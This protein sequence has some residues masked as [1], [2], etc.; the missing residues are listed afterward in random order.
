MDEDRGDHVRLQRHPPATLRRKQLLWLK[1]VDSVEDQVA[2]LDS[3]EAHSTE[4]NAGP[5]ARVIGEDDL[6][7][8]QRHLPAVREDN[9]RPWWTVLNDR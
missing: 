7:G 8:W 3:L 1:I 9:K 5:A 2:V 6:I 4:A